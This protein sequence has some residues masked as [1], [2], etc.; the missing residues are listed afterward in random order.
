[1]LWRFQESLI[2]AQLYLLDVEG[3]LKSK[4]PNN[5]ENNDQIGR[6]RGTVELLV[7]NY[8]TSIGTISIIREQSDAWTIFK[9]K[10]R[11]AFT[12]EHSK[13]ILMKEGI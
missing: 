7:T 1:M 8:C 4:I 6:V 2:D 9:N 5:M 13:K 3:L 11:H 10:T 12:H